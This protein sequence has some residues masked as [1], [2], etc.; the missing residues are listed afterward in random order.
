[1]K[2]YRLFF[3]TLTIITILSLSV[4]LYGKI[5]LKHFNESSFL[6]TAYYFSF[7]N[8]IDFFPDLKGFLLEENS[9]FTKEELIDFAEEVLIVKNSSKKEYRGNGITNSMQVIKTIKGNLKEG[10][11]VIVYD[12]ISN[13]REI[14]LDSL[15]GFVPLQKNETYLVFL[16]KAVNPTMSDSYA[17][18]STQYGAL[19]LKR[20][21]QIFYQYEQLSF[22]VEEAMNYDYITELEESD[23]SMIQMRKLR[24]E[25][26]EYGNFLLEE[27]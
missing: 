23:N 22:K 5:T 10:Q 4:F 25:L 16:K 20:E 3:L 1:M 6:Q 2:K 14:E 8:Y 24:N 26:K 15:S 9:A 17:L 12:L 21:D 19:P 27:S 18:I 13:F 11:T 7:D